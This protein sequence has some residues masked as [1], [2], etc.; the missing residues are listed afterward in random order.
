MKVTKNNVLKSLFT[1][2]IVPIYKNA[3][4]GEEFQYDDRWNRLIKNF[5]LRRQRLIDELK[6][7]MREVNKEEEE[8]LL[9]TGLSYRDNPK[10]D[11]Y[12][13]FFEE[14]FEIIDG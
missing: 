3:I 13:P 14:T 1:D 10:T 5:P 4:T 2:S 9:I 11:L 12:Y 8:L 7:N 6:Q